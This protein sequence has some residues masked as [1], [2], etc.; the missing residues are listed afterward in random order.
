MK[1]ARPPFPP[2]LFARFNQ[3]ARQLGYTVR[4]ERWKLLDLLLEYAAEHPALF[5]KR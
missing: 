2:A 1:Y 4:G 5:K 3:V